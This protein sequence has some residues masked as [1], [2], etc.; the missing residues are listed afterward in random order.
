MPVI[1]VVGAAPAFAASVAQALRLDHELAPWQYSLGTRALRLTVTNPTTDDLDVV[2][3]YAENGPDGTVT[4]PLFGGS[5][6]WTLQKV[7]GQCVVTGRVGAGATSPAF[8][9]VWGTAAADGI[10]QTALLTL[11][12]PG[13]ATVVVPVPLRFDIPL[14]SPGPGP[15]LPD[16]P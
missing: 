11:A 8:T 14:G 5:G 1:A 2:V 10:A 16:R 9:Q 3:T 15:G 6:H 12:A 4:F 13:L 7:D